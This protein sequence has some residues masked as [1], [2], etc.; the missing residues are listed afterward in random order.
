MYAERVR[1]DIGTANTLIRTMGRLGD[2]DSAIRV[3]KAVRN[4]VSTTN[5]HSKYPNIHTYSALI[6]A[7][8]VSGRVET[9]FK[10]VAV[11]RGRCGER[12]VSHA[13]RVRS[14]PPPRPPATST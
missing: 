9:A 14:L 10:C 2:I 4:S 6:K 8:L 5:R 3:Y 7:A 11:L 12:I 1:M 13:C